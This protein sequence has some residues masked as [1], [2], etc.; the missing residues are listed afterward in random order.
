MDK[1]H[2]DP[3]GFAL[4]LRVAAG[5]Q[6]GS[7]KSTTLS[8]ALLHDEEA[9]QPSPSMG[10]FR[11]ADTSNGMPIVCSMPGT[12]Q[13]IK[14]VRV[15]SGTI[16]LQC[17]TPMQPANTDSP[18][19]SP[20]PGPQS[21]HPPSSCLALPAGLLS[22]HRH[23]HQRAAGSGSRTGPP[24]SSGDICSPSYT[25]TTARGFHIFDDW[26]ITRYAHGSVG[27]QPVH[28]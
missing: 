15:G 6:S 25:A 20:T 16:C 2:M 5:L 26:G 23:Q 24:S 10:G 4:P 27:E 3:P 1:G 22:A 19:C 11:H 18:A 9:G 8:T 7:A 28:L 13:P 14:M 21:C 12:T 17:P